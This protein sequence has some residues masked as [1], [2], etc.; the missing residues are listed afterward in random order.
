MNKKQTICMWLGIVAILCITFPTAVDLLEG[1]THA[2]QA[3]GVVFCVF[4]IAVVTAGLIVTFRDKKAKP[5]DASA[6]EN[7]KKPK[8][9]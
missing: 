3:T 4:C 7:G 9:D 8:D 2:R 5:K 6:K 1:W